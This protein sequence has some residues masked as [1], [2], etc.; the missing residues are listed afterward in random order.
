MAKP[1]EL[2]MVNIGGSKLIG[3]SNRKLVLL[4]AQ[5]RRGVSGEYLCDHED[6]RRLLEWL[7]DVLRDA[8][9]EEAEDRRC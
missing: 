5:D 9:V 1:N 3:R 6:A 4:K 8:G 2:L 7:R